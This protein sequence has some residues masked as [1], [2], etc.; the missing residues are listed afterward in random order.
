[1]KHVIIMPDL[2]QITSEAKIVSWLKEVGDQLAMGE[3]L[4]EVET[5]KATMD[6]EAYVGGYLRKRL[7][8]A[9]EMVTASSPVAIL[10]DGPDEDFEE[11]PQ[12]KPGAGRPI[13]VTSQE[14]PSGFAPAAKRIA[15][16]PAAR[17]LAQ[18][19]GV[20]LQAVQG[21]GPQGLITSADV[22]RFASQAPGKT[23]SGLSLNEN[24]AL[25]AMAALTS[26]SKTTIPHFYVSAD[27]DVAAAEQWR[28]KWN[29]SH[30]GLKASV[31]DYLLRSASAALAD[32]PQLNVRIVNGKY[33]QQSASDILVVAGTD[34]GLML[35]PVADP[36]AGTFEAYLSRV[37]SLLSSA[38]EG[39]HPA[40]SAQATP[41]LAISNLGMYGVKE[42]S[43]IVPPGCSAILAA[44]AVREQVVSRKG[45]VEVAT[46]CS[47]TVSADH[48]VADGI[49][50]A[51]FLERMQVHLNSL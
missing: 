32:C 24:K 33:E 25:Q 4:L 14:A 7:A 46:V 41:S 40:T 3:P 1:M 27:L 19:L 16:V 29:K 47:V 44:G 17:A 8:R 30:P 9:G 42:F 2:G 10:T 21:T 31:N 45:R 5:D 39:K 51:K 48:R 11:D 18:R 26:K 12:A 36:L 20:E 13:P 6:V 38:N 23:G 28:A 15:A 22:E 50:V 43:A 37:K 49:A 34:H 35:V